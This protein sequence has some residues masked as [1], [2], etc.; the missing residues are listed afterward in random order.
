MTTVCSLE[1]F[2]VAIVGAH[3]LILL[4]DVEGEDGLVASREEIAEPAAE[5]VQGVGEVQAHF[6][7]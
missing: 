6:L 3:F 4:A 5:R 7:A 2:A 1:A